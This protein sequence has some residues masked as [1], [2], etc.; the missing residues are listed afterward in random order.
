MNLR[1]I[2]SSLL[3]ALLIASFASNAALIT[4]EVGYD[5]PIIDLSAFENGSYNF[6]FG[7]ES[8]PGGITFTAAPGGGGNSGNGSVIGQGSYGLVDNGNFGGDAVYIGVDSG[9]GFAQLTFDTEV[10][11]FGAYFNYAPGFGDAPTIFALDD[12][13]NVI[14]SYDLSAAAPISTPG[15][16]NEFAFR[17][18]DLG[19]STMKTFRFGGSFIL[20]AGTPDGRVV[21]EPPM[22]VSSPSA[23]LLLLMGVFALRARKF[24]A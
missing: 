1:T 14:E 4:N 23:L 22:S 10:S 12:M 18:I 11:F 5:G 17:G 2:K 24:K 8:L 20:L 21:E 6:T 3:G 13:D 7:P 16:F 19:M 9:T 15:G